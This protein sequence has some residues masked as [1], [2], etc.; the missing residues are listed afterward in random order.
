MTLVR[1]NLHIFPLYFKIKNSIYNYSLKFKRFLLIQENFGTKNTKN[2]LLILVPEY[3]VVPVSHGIKKRSLNDVFSVVF[4]KVF[5]S[6]L[7]LYLEPTKGILAGNGTRVWIAEPDSSAPN[8]V[9]YELI[10]E[11]SI[12][13]IS[14]QVC[15]L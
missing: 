15:I 5:G 10:S 3:E 2:L 9:K 7:R 6:D 14:R 1:K 4:L 11:V 8:G 13:N 12:R